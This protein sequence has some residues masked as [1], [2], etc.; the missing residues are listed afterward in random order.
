MTDYHEYKKIS[1]GCSDIASLTIRTCAVPGESPCTILK[2]LDFGEDGSYSAY[3]VDDDAEIGEHYEVV[4][5]GHFWMTIYDDN[6]VAAKID[7]HDR[8]DGGTI[9]VYRAGM[10]GCII[11]VSGEKR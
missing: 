3:L 6:G 1:L 10:R 5:E 9:R 8:V 7:A 11:Q 4:C 2:A